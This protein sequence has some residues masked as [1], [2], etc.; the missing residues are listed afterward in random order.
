MTTMKTIFT[1]KFKI[2]KARKILIC[3]PIVR[4]RNSPKRKSQRKNK[5]KKATS[6][7]SKIL[8]NHK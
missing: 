2:A 8:Q 6:L 3:K 4:L 5:S 1:G 7:I